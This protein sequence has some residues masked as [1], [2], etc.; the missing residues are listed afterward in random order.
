LTPKERLPKGIPDWFVDADEDGDG[1]V[2]MAEYS[3]RL[4]ESK[5]K[6]FARRDLDGDGVITPREAASGGR[7]RDE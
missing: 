5:A 2:L 6:E 4:T 3:D 1:Q 7:S